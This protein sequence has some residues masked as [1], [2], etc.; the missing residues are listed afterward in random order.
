VTW[1]LSRVPLARVT[2]PGEEAVFSFAITAPVALGGSDFQWQMVQDG[3]EWFGDATTPL[4]VAS[5]PPAEP[6]RCDELRRA[7]SEVDAEIARLTD[8]LIDDPQVDGP[9]LLAITRLRTRRAA[10]VSEAEGLGCAL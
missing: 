6:A 10:H 1:G 5:V 2:P 9:R 4:I 8:L 7:I 3:V